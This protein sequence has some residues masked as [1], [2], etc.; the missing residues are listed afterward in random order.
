MASINNDV[1]PLS[2]LTLILSFISLGIVTTILFLNIE[3]E[4]Y[5]LLLALDTFICGIFLFQWA[6]DFS[7]APHKGQYV[8][9]HWID[10]MASLPI[11]EPLRFARVFQIFRV[12]RIL[13]AGRDLL[14]S[15][16]SHR[17]ETTLASILLL[18]TIQLTVGSTFVLMA[19][20]GV[21]GANITGPIDALWW[22][23]VTVSTVGYGDYYPVSLAG[24]VIAVVVIVG[25]VGIFGM[26]SGLISA[27]INAE[28]DSEQ[29]QAIE[30]FHQQQ[31]EILATS[32]AIAAQQQALL[33]RL[34]HLENQMSEQFESTQRAA[35]TEQPLTVNAVTADSP[36]EHKDNEKAKDESDNQIP[37]KENKPSSN[38]VDS[39]NSPD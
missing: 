31:A 30:A 35:S 6:V 24:K 37:S 22:A 26:I 11:I 14:T 5:P 2:L 29:R 20:R 13:R 1:R 7:R 39:K 16:Q 27:T 25:G 33:A 3:H 23:I 4:A 38:N 21:E 12:I 19:E 8:K 9:H 17:R 28:D 36:D 10:L 18:L 32:K 34:E 15:I